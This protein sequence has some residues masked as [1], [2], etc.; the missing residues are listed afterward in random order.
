M[1]QGT[2]TAIMLNEMKRNTLAWNPDNNNTESRMGE[3]RWRISDEYLVI[4]EREMA[5]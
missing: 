2:V 3:S 1:N 5:E 4:G